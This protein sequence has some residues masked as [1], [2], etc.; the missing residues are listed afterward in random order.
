MLRDMFFTLPGW[1]MFFLGVFLATYVKS[2]I[3]QVKSKAGA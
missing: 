3:G 1:L 2:A